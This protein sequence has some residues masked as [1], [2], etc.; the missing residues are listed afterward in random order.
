MPSAAPSLSPSRADSDEAL[1][2]RHQRGLWRFLRWLGADPVLADDLLQDTFLR[3]LQ[4]PP[5]DRSDAAVAAWLRTTAT[6]LFRSSGR[7]AR[8]GV[9]VDDAE[10]LEAVWQEHARDDGG[11]GYQEALAACLQALPERT[12]QALELRYRHALGEG[13]LAIA[14]GLRPGGVKTLLRRARELL[15]EC[16]R[17]RER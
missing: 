13:E 11:D 12:R 8:A 17:R 15:A 7:R 14:L 2:R 5:A 10:V 3:F 9:Q 16:I 6:N 1:I 4:R